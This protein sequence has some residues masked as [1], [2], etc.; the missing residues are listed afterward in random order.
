MDDT[1]SDRREALSARADSPDG[2]I[3]AE[4]RGRSDLRIRFR[5]SAYAAYSDRE[6]AAQLGR[7]GTTVWARYHRDYTEL[8]RSYLGEPA[9]D[10]AA[11]DGD[12]LDR[13][14]HL[15]VTGRS[16][17]GWVAVSSRALARWEV[18][19][20]DGAVST[21]PEDTFLSELLA[22]VTAALQEYQDRLILLTAATYDVGAPGRSTVK[23]E[24]R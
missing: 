22:A 20:A 18:S 2:R 24:P 1:L 6:L 15:T 11:A 10:R 14:E 16:P 3:S 5:A 19:V 21:L 9:P 7:L 4:I 17:H 13:A 12:F 8:T 23:G